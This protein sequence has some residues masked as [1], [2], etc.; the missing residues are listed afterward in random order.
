M[1]GSTVPTVE[2]VR[3]EVA[4]LH[5][6]LQANDVNCWSWWTYVDDQSATVRD[7]LNRV[8]TF[9]GSEDSSKP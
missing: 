7:M 6:A 8:A 1:D 2:D 4:K 3:V 5:E 9:H